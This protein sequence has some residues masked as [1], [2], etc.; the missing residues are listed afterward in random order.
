MWPATILTPT[1]WRSPQSATE[2]FSRTAKRV[3]TI[4]SWQVRPGFAATPSSCEDY[5]WMEAAK[6]DRTSGARRKARP[7]RLRQ[8]QSSNE[9]LALS[10]KR[11][12]TGCHNR[13]A[14]LNRCCSPQSASEPP[15]SCNFGRALR[16]APLARAVFSLEASLSRGFVGIEDSPRRAGGRLSAPSSQGAG[17]GQRKEWGARGGE[18]KERG[19]RGGER[20]QR[21]ARGG[22]AQRKEPAS[23]AGLAVPKRKGSPTRADDPLLTCFLQALPEARS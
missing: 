17:E 22:G 23:R 1:G 13:K 11:V 15:Q 4:S 21:G 19:A 16:R 9:L 2:L 10:A 20:K 18:R 6:L 5:F 3:R 12:R 14:R 8:P 7:S